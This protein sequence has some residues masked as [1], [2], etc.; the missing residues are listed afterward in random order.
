MNTALWI[1]QILLALAFFMS[2]IMKI[3]Q[4]I[5]RLKVR[6]TYVESIHPSSLVR[7]IGT[8]EDSQ[9]LA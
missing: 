8:L 5:D 7:V 2:G 1:V 6:M 3:T 4:P 9:Q